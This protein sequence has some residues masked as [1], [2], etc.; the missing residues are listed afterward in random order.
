MA[1][2]CAP[3][4]R[5]ERQPDDN[6]K[7]A[8]C[9]K[10]HSIF[11]RFSQCELSFKVARPTTVP[12]SQTA[13]SAL[14][15]TTATGS[16]SIS[17]RRDDDPACADQPIRIAGTPNS[18]R[19]VKSGLKNSLRASTRHS[20]PARPQQRRIDVLV[21][22]SPRLNRGEKPEKSPLFGGVRKLSGS[23]A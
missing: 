9:I 21:L 10:R 4:Y 2:P 3:Y 15:G 14:A 1:V 18:I 23:P 22:L 13:E 19:S 6:S 17:K 5:H 16:G 7:Y 11:L 8:V 20:S 12:A